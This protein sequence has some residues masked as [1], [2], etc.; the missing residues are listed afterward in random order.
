MINSDVL[1][2]LKGA[3]AV[4]SVKKEEVNF[5]C[6]VCNHQRFYF[7]WKKRLGFCHRASCGYKPNLKD[8]VELKG[9]GPDDYYVSTAPAEPVMGK[10]AKV[11]L[12][13]GTWPISVITD[14]WLVK[15]LQ[16]RGVTMQKITLYDLLGFANR[17]YIPITHQG[18][19]VQYIGRAIDR[20]KDPED[21]FKTD[22][23]QRF[24]YAKGKPITQ[25]IF[26][27]ETAR[28]WQQLTLV[29]S[30][31]NAIAW[32]DKFNCTTNFGSHLSDI[33]VDMLAH[34][35][36]KHVV[37]AWD[38]DAWKK[39]HH[40]AV[41]LGRV[42]I[43]SAILVYEKEHNQPDQVPYDKLAHTIEQTY[44]VLNKNAPQVGPLRSMT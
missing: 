41:K 31:F 5:F 9:Y 1:S 12:P 39:A 19:L 2:W 3:F 25:F 13:G 6:P 15:A 36:V 34:S 26:D 23:L 40:A 21:G 33:Q 27:W 14:P 35:H 30:T 24:L 32:G 8:L 42:G 29:E 7:N 28:N 10:P 18:E 11:E 37:F 4:Q 22:H 38:K 44:N 43:K 20:T 17:V 16:Y